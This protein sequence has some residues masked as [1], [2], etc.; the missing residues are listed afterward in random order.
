MKAAQAS[1]VA[2]GNS[3]GI[4]IPKSVIQQCRLDAAS[5][6]AVLLTVTPRGLLVSPAVTP[7]QGWAEQFQRARAEHP[8]GETIESW[9]STRFDREEWEW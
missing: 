8:S 5:D 4:R 7:R 2:I 9:P 6:Q 3:R 1:L